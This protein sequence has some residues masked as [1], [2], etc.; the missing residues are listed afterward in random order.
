AA[1]RIRVFHAR[2]RERSWSF[3]D[4]TGARLGQRIE[5][6][7]RVGVY[8]PGGRAVYPSTVL[9]TVVTARVAGVREVVA[10][11]PTAKT[12]DHPLILAA[13]HVAGVDRLYRL[14]G[15]QAIAALAFRPEPVP[16]VDPIVRPA[17]IHAPPPTPLR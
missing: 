17:H 6:L 3:R 12:G 9:M 14:G 2:Q 5:P 15:A 16:R 13:C 8:I 11:T 10:V 1:R 7:A 4:A